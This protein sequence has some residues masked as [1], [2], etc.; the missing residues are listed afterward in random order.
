MNNIVI[1]YSFSKIPD[2][3][4]PNRT[5]IKQVYGTA[6]FINTS[7]SL[8]TCYDN[9]KYSVYVSVLIDGITYNADIV[10][11]CPEKNLALLN[12]NKY[13]S[14]PLP[15]GD[16]NIYHE[17]LTLYG[18]SSET[19]TIDCFSF[20]PMV[21]NSHFFALSSSY[22]KKGGPVV[23]CT[24]R[25]VGINV[26]STNVDN[27]NKYKI[28]KI[29]HFICLVNEFTRKKIIQCPK[30]YFKFNVVDNDYL[31]VQNIFDF[32]PFYKIGL[33][34]GHKII[35]FNNMNI[36][37]NNINDIIDTMNVNDNIYIEYIDNNN[38]IKKK[39]NLNNNY[40]LPLKYINFPFENIVYE[41]IGGL[42]FTELS[43]NH[44]QKISRINFINQTEKNIL[45]K[46]KKTKNRQKSV[47]FI[48]FV[49]EP[50]KFTINPGT[51]INSINSK[52]VNTI[53]DL[54]QEFCCNEIHTIETTNKIINIDLKKCYL[55]DIELSTTH[56][57]DI[58]SIYKN[59]TFL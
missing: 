59:K 49:Y 30:L 26:G 47:L 42:I 17:T 35:K 12:I 19:K 23:D 48:S 8:L 58:S 32:S 7:G 16:P 21:I 57:Y 40:Q 2:L 3:F 22:L 14:N 55:I 27:I 29:S 36:N 28:I 31:F 37:K 46:F 18:Y 45:E 54:K 33:R 1:I 24:G 4:M 44:L 56:N 15:M 34:S 25:V 9:V 39:V 10:S 41:V 11:I 20:R 5:K 51:V 50:N 13:K 52:N 6:F 53:N 43:I 38:K